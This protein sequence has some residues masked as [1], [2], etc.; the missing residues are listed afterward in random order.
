MAL[1]VAG[2][3]ITAVPVVVAK[4]DAV[5][6]SHTGVPLTRATTFRFTLDVNPEQRQR[7]RAH[8]GAFRLAFN[9]HIGRVKANLDQRAAQRSYGV[10]DAD[11][12]PSLS[13]SKVSFINDMNAW[14]DGRGLTHRPRWTRPLASSCVGFRGGVRC[15]R[16]CSRPHR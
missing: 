8:A 14:K 3:T 2:G 6:V 9:H 1:S 15:R 10:S 7:L 13:W 16:T 11:L 5:L 12:T 4:S